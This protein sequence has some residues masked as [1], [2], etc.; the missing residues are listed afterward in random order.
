MKYLGKHPFFDSS[1]IAT[2]PLRTRKNKVLWQNLIEPQK[3]LSSASAPAG[4]SRAVAPI[5]EAIARACE[6]NWPVIL[7]TGAHLLKNGFGRLVIDWM[8]RGVIT[9]FA[10]NSAGTIHDFELALIGETSEYVPDA[11]GRGRFGMAYEFSYI[12][13]AIAEGNR[14][15]LGYG[16]SL[17]RMITDGEFRRQVLQ[18]VW[19]EGA[20]REFAHPEVSVLAAS[21]QFGVPVTVHTTVG[22]DVIDQ[23]PSFDGEAK[24]GT[25]GRDFLIFAEHVRGFKQGG[26]L[27]NMGSAVTGPEVFLKCISMVCNIGNVPSS[28]LVT[29][30]FDIR[31]FTPGAMTDERQ[32]G[33]YFRDQKSVVTRIPQAFGGRGFYVEGDQVITLPELFRQTAQVRRAT[34]TVQDYTK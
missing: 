13:E 25:S 4:G 11:L 23:H 24:G 19:R 17:S 22:G 21:P 32:F 2:Y 29:A 34:A 12:N 20:P 10:T 6:Q 3:V 28:E 15:A 33:Y 7:F 16:E 18:R 30:D 14:R 9:L 8:R 27:L 5:A 1:R 26:V 31:P